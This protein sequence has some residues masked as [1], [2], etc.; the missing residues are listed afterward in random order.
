MIEGQLDVYECIEIAEAEC[1][2]CPDS[3][4]CASDGCVSLDELPESIYPAWDDV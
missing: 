4:L 1:D 3:T 2:D